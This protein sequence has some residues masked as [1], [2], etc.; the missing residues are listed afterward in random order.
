MNIR[1]KSEKCQLPILANN[2][3]SDRVVRGP[4]KSPGILGGVKCNPPITTWGLT[5][6]DHLPV[7]TNMHMSGVTL[8]FEHQGLITVNDAD[9]GMSVNGT[10]AG[11]YYRIRLMIPMPV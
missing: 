8:S 11:R 1:L 10:E 7:G 3:L 6:T 5:S 4:S 2:G 9:R